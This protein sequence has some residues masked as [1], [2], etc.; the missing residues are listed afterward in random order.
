MKISMLIGI[1]LVIMAIIAFGYIGVWEKLG[2]AGEFSSAKIAS[3]GTKMRFR[4]R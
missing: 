2:G 1:C 4:C 3:D